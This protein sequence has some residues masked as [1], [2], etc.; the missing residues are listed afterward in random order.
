M[1]KILN[2]KILQSDV[3]LALFFVPTVCGRLLQHVF[4]IE[5]LTFVIEQVIRHVAMKGP[6]L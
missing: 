5:I 2:K 6:R 1:F 3:F 4:F